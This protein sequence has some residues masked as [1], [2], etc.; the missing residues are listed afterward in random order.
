MK[1]LAV[2]RSA[3][4]SK[5]S[6]LARAPLSGTEFDWQSYGNSAIVWSQKSGNQ[7]QAPARRSDL[8]LSRIPRPLG[9]GSHFKAAASKAASAILMARLHWSPQVN[10]R[11]PRPCGMLARIERLRKMVLTTH[12]TMMEQRKL[13]SATR[14]SFSDA[15]MPDARVD[16]PALPAPK[17]LRSEGQK[18]LL[19]ISVTTS[20]Y[21]ITLADKEVRPV[22]RDVS[23]AFNQDQ[24]KALQTKLPP[25]RT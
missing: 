6:T 14:L 13:L 1:S 10:P 17:S 2:Y 19:S 18:S 12:T 15:V 9:C 8:A 25:L 24:T 5:S 22:M 21:E 3:E 20:M 16:L 23:R 11:F 7:L 4:E